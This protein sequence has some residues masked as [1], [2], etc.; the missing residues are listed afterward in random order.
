MNTS[1]QGRH[2]A[3]LG[4][5]AAPPAAKTSDAGATIARLSALPRSAR[6]FRN[7]L[8]IAEAFVSGT[9]GI[10]FHPPKAPEARLELLRR[11][12]RV[13]HVVALADCLDAALRRPVARGELAGIVAAFLSGHPAFKA[14]AA[15]GLGSFLGQVAE[16]AA[17]ERWAAVEVAAGMAAVMREARFMPSPAEAIEAIGEARRFLTETTAVARMAADRLE[18]LAFSLELAGLPGFAVAG[19]ETTSGKGDD[20]DLQV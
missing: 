11:A 3:N 7:N 20:D 6:A 17:E 4:H 12:P 19:I 1:R 5:N 13:D 16:A 9:M 10:S 2:V 8:A 14:F 18:R 15:E